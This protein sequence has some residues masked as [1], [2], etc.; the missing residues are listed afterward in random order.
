M[1]YKCTFFKTLSIIIYV[2]M[3]CLCVCVC[4]W[5]KTMSWEN[6]EPLHGCGSCMSDVTVEDGL[7]TRGAAIAAK[8]C[9]SAAQA[10]DA[11][12]CLAL[13]AEPQKQQRA[14]FHRH[15]DRKNG[16]NQ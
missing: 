14:S 4:G 10:K 16:R 2:Y 9:E 7:N 6:E 15:A 1:Y 3:I 13:A 12:G 8:L 11:K 5:V